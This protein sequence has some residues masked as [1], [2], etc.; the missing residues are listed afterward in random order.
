MTDGAVDRSD[1]VGAG[2]DRRAVVA[3]LRAV[4]LTADEAALVADHRAARAGAPV[5]P[6]TEGLA[7]AV[8]LAVAAGVWV[9]VVRLGA[10]ALGLDDDRLAR[11]AILLVVPALVVLLGLRRGVDGRTWLRLAGGLAL[12]ALAANAVP[13]A[14]D[15]AGTDT[16][17]LAALHL[18]V[19]GWAVVLVA[20]AGGH[21]RDA[22]RRLEAVRF[23]G[24]VGVLVVLMALGGAVLLGVTAG[25]VTT[26]GVDAEPLAEW[27]LPAGAAGAVVIAGWLVETRPRLAGGLAPVLAQVFTPLF[28]AALGGVLVV[29]AAR[30][31]GTAFDRDT[32]ALLDALMVVVLGLAVY[33]QAARTPGRGPG[34]DDRL[35]LVAVGAALVLDAGVLVA[36]VVRVGDLGTTPNRIAALGLNLV[37]LVALAG[38]ARALGRAVRGRG[39][40]AEVEGWLARTVPMLVA[41]AAFVAVV[42]PLLPTAGP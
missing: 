23:S 35:R 11:N 40:M 39:P 42:L 25:L 31:G 5:A 26:V 41:W 33:G 7:P 9:H 19:L 28:G 37:L 1:G 27:V 6:A 34:W 21:V 2:A 16:A 24:E 15:A 29:F 20:H 13:H 38:T 12:V 36:M 3:A 8:V 32:V 30:G 18:P 4:G 17:L 22:A 14:S 10:G